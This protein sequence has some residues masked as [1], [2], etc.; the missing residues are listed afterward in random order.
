MATPELHTP[1]RPLVLS[2][3]LCHRLHGCLS[4]TYSFIHL[5]TSIHISPSC[6]CGFYRSKSTLYFPVSIFFLYFVSTAP[7][8]PAKP[9]VTNATQCNLLDGGRIYVR[10]FSMV[11]AATV[12]GVSGVDNFAVVA[13]AAAAAVVIFIVFLVAFRASSFVGR[14]RYSAPSCG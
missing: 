5:C 6:L 4:R 8:L 3:L 2:L 11:L 7:L 12:A 14:C 10:G 13:A 9:R 1:I